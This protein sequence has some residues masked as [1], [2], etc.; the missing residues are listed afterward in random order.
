[1][2]G[3]LILC[4]TPIGN[5]GDA[6][7]RLA[8]TLGAVDLIYA[9]DTRRAGILLAHLGV[10]AP[11]RSYFAGNED[12]RSIELARR[13]EKGETVALITEAGMPS[14]SDPGVSAVAA[15]RS[16][17]AEVTVVPGPS[18]VLAA[19][20]LSGFPSERFVFEGFLPRRG[21]E[22][23]RRLEEI[24]TETR[25]IVVFT[26]PH[27]FRHDLLDLEEV[28]GGDRPVA[29]CRE[30]TKR[31]EEV[32]WG[33]VAEA[34]SR[35]EAPKGE[36]TIVIRGAGPPSRDLEAGLRLV[37]DRVAAGSTRASAVRAVAAE[38]GLSR[39]EL[40][41]AVLAGDRS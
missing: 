40:Y 18:A 11:V 29:V 7:R 39:R 34:T 35:F 16:V 3:R 24:A 26:A 8:E 25:T 19:L 12:Q 1:M 38:L 30:L 13:L 2:P 5:L 22:R 33:P 10:G 15:A 41:G 9:E 27:R 28:C 17:D 6:P 14:V 21:G 20:V 36:F 31:Y 23:R 4:A 32:W 37:G